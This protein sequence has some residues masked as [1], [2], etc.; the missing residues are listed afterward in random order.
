MLF[1]KVNIPKIFLCN[2]HVANINK[3]GQPSCAK[4]L[5]AWLAGLGWKSVRERG[6]VSL[7]M[8]KASMGQAGACGGG[9]TTSPCGHQGDSKEGSVIPNSPQHCSIFYSLS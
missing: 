6:W 8:I 7:I 5:F 3:F 1:F 9:Q 2:I 4:N